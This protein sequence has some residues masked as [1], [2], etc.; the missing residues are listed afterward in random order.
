[1]GYYGGPSRFI[2]FAIGAGAATFWHKCHQMN[3]NGAPWGHCRRSAIQQ[4]HP[5]PNPP[6]TNPDG[7]STPTQAQESSFSYKD[8]PKR[9]NNIPPANWE[10]GQEKER[11]RNQEDEDR[12]ADLRRQAT[13]TVSPNCL[14]LI[15]TLTFE[16]FFFC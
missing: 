16:V 13:E 9:I 7:S 5:Y 15:S 14:F 3:Y 12:L 2:W 6:P 4:Q 1:M 10:W 8:I 11:L